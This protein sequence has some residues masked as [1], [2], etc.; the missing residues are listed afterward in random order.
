MVVKV[1]TADTWNFKSLMVTEQHTLK[2]VRDMASSKMKI[3]AKSH[4]L[5][6]SSDIK[7]MTYFDLRSPG[8]ESLEKSQSGDPSF[9]LVIGAIGVRPSMSYTDYVQKEKERAK[10]IALKEKSQKKESGFVFF[11]FFLSFSLSFSFLS[12]SFSFLLSP[13]GIF[14][15]L[16]NRQPKKGDDFVPILPGQA[17]ALVFF[18]FIYTSFP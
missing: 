11:I 7:G 4:T 9:K 12:L 17:N 2:D 16:T 1:Y 18:N 13:Y 14:L 8:L 10:Q 15:S 6:G 3:D 5:Y